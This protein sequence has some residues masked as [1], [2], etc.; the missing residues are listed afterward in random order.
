MSGN[1]RFTRGPV[2]VQ[3]TRRPDREDKLVHITCGADPETAGYRIAYRGTAEQVIA[4]LEAVS[5]ELWKY[6]AAGTEPDVTT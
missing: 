1:A 6:R 3:V 4:C 2:P 5:R